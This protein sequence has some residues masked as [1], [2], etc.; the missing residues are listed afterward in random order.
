MRCS[1]T[2]WTSCSWSTVRRMT[3]QLRHPRAAAAELLGLLKHS[4]KELV[5]L[6]RQIDK[7]L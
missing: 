4:Y 6:R 5:D 3:V 7:R 1:G 2:W